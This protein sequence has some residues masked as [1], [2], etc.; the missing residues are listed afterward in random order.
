L[1]KANLCY[2]GVA[3]PIRI[4]I[5]GYTADKIKLKIAHAKVIKKED[6]LF[7]V[8]FDKIP[9]GKVYAYVEATNKQGRTSTVHSMELK[10]KNLPAPIT[11]FESY[12]ETGISLSEFK[13]FKGLHAF[14]SDSAFSMD[15][16]IISFQVEGITHNHQYIEPLTVYGAAFENN[17]ELMSQFNSASVGDKFIFSNIRAKATNGKEYEALP[18]SILLK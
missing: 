2:A 16:E 8:Y 9:N 10:V 13:S 6:D 18:F 12:K 4:H 1:D 14:A 7:E 11:N 17:H 5:P 3:N 15:Y